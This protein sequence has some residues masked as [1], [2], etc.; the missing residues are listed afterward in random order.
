M[1]IP[2]LFP[3]P[4][5]GLKG[6]EGLKTHVAVTD[7]HHSIACHSEMAV[8]TLPVIQEATLRKAVCFSSVSTEM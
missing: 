8:H 5:R 3:V 7:Q 4:L 6:E 1:G 2:A